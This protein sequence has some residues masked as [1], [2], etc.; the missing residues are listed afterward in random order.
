MAAL[1]AAI[2]LAVVSVVQSGSGWTEEAIRLADYA[3][4]TALPKIQQKGED[5]TESISDMMLFLMPDL[6][7]SNTADSSPVSYPDY[8]TIDPGMKRLGTYA[9]KQW[10]ALPDS[11]RVFIAER[12]W[13]I[14]VTDDPYWEEFGHD[15]VSGMTVF[16]R[17]TCFITDS[18]FC[19]KHALYHEIGHLID[20]ESGFPSKS[21]EFQRI[22]ESES[23]RWKE[24]DDLKGYGRSNS[25]EYFAET[26]QY[27]L[28]YGD[29]YAETAPETYAF[30]RRYIP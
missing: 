13:V 17:K 19:V 30:V 14:R 26:F 11:I 8:L 9:N 2:V 3:A 23:D 18:R 5:L 16:S 20:M 6:M 25:L 1:L 22:Y 7:V 21:E 4:D 12:G 28:R 27:I 10:N 29:R 15:P 24:V